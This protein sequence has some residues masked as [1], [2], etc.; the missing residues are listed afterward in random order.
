MRAVIKGRTL[1]ALVLP[2]VCTGAFWL[3]LPAAYRASESSD[4]S[5]FYEPVAVRLLAGQGITTE[6]GAVAMRYPPGFPIVL[7]AAIGTG[8]ALGLSEEHVLDVLALACVAISSLLL[9]LIAREIWS[10]WAALVPSA[11][12]S[13]YPLVLWLTKQPNSE[14]VFT[15]LLFACAFALWKLTRDVR[16]RAGMVLAMGACAGAAM[17]VR[18]IA[19]FLPLVCGALVMVLAKEWS[20]RAR[21][22]TAAS[23][24]AVALLVV[25]PWELRASRGAGHFVMLSDGGVPAMR[26]GLTF[27]VN[28][29]KDY[30]GGIRVPDAVRTVMVSFYAQYDQLDTY[31]AIA[32]ATLAACGRSPAG[33]AGLVVL[34][35]VRAWY[36]TDS[37]R[38]EGYIAVIQLVYLA[39]LAC[40][41][42][43]AL[44]AGGE[45]KRLALI[46][47][48]ILILFW[49]MSVLAL[50]LVRYMVPAI[51]IAFVLLPAAGQKV[52][53]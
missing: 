21:A 37:Q 35:L 45:R 7:A 27:A 19:L 20:V 8:R 29:K 3:V 49:C 30:R 50:P 26:D 25:L 14:L 46:V 6:S 9:H 10:G 17:L 36:G 18:P 24:L 31:G 34:K 52:L 15:P 23:V 4:F 1:I 38:L 16:P 22:V 13:T 2:V 5:S 40:A 42:Y 48:S 53:R 33:M 12:W 39:L 28:T 47:A 41:W 32:W 43:V 44:R 11:A 51:G